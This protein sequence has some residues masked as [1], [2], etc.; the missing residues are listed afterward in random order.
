[1]ELCTT[2]EAVCGHGIGNVALTNSLRPPTALRLSANNARFS[3]NIEPRRGNTVTG[4]RSNIYYCLS[5]FINNTQFSG[6]GLVPRQSLKSRGLAVFSEGCQLSIVTSKRS[7]DSFLGCLRVR[8]MFWHL[9]NA[10][11]LSLSLLQALC[12]FAALEGMY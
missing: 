7:S 3:T 5:I 6:A 8:L 4:N 10:V 11:E 12:M 9:A 2:V 1:M